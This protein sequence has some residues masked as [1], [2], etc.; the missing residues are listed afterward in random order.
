MLKLKNLVLGILI[1]LLMVNTCLA[2]VEFQIYPGTRYVSPGETVS[3]D[4]AVSLKNLSDDTVFPV[5][6]NFSIDPRMPGWGYSFSED[7]VILDL[8]RITNSSV[9]EIAVPSNATAGTYSHKVI[10][11]EYDSYSK[12]TGAY[13]TDIYV[14]NTNVQV[15]E[16]PTVALPMLAVFGLVAIFGKRNHKD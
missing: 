16:F 6:E 8:A 3:Y 1:L 2:V 10:A 7:S 12:I 5:T 4:L 13:D 14:I 15:P 11:K 9:L